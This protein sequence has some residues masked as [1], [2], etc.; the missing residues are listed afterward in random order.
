M[1]N[2]TPFLFGC[3]TE[4]YDQYYP[5]DYYRV[6][7]MHPTASGGCSRTWI[8]RVCS[9]CHGLCLIVR[10]DREGIHAIVA[11]DALNIVQ[12]FK[13]PRISPA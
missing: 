5:A 13:T 10:G 4:Q 2:A 1:E 7:F 12:L 3:F 9:F 6:L 11:K 8:L